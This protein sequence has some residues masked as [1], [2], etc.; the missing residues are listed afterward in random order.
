MEF[1][2]VVPAVAIVPALPLHTRLLAFVLKIHLPFTTGRNH[3]GDVNLFSGVRK[4][5]QR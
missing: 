4:T 2:A 1:P 3:F 5:Q